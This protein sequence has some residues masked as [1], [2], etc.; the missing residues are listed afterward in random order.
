MNY[1]NEAHD[2]V[3]NGRSDASRA[4]DNAHKLGLMILIGKPR[5]GRDEKSS[6]RGRITQTRTTPGASASPRNAAGASRR[7]ARTV[8]PN[9]DEGRSK[10]GI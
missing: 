7:Q 5:Q 6:L 9:A 1:P 8:N 2:R 10:P 4:R 3:R